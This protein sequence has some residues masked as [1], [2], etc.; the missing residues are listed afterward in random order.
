MNE[1]KVGDVICETE[2]HPTT[3]LERFEK[4]PKCNSEAMHHVLQAFEEED[5]VVIS[6]VK[7]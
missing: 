6:D 5:E 2:W 7:A 3:I 1:P 4:C